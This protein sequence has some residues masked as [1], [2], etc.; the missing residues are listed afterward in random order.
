MTG[1]RVAEIG[2]AAGKHPQDSFAGDEHDR[3]TG[4]LVV[5]HA[6]DEGG[7]YPGGGA[8]E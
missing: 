5:A 8:L 4:H 1:V 3:G 6:G 7:V 2:D